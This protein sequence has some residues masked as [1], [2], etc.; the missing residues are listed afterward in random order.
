MIEHTFNSIPRRAAAAITRRTSL[1][2]MGAAGL[3][4]LSRAATVDA[5]KND[6]KNNKREKKADKKVKKECQAELAQCT[7]EATQCAAQVEQCTGVFNT[8]CRGDPACADQIACCS[9]L[10]SCDVNAFFACLVVSG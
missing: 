5:K 3:A 6:K 8:V 4:A 10:A 1:T 7:T 9:K 2:T